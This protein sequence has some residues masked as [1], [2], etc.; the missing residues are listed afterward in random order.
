MR[1]SLATS[2]QNRWRMVH[3]TLVL[4]YFI[5]DVLG[6][7]SLYIVIVLL[8]RAVTSHLDLS[9]FALLY[10]SIALLIKAYLIGG[11]SRA[12]WSQTC[13]YVRIACPLV[14]VIA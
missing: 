2:V 10:M 8:F 3:Q 12:S 7:A 14:C 13:S 9:V 4:V 5:I 6:A 1:V 11:G